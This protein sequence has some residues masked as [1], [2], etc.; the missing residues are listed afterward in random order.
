VSLSFDTDKGAGQYLGEGFDL[1]ALD[2]LFLVFP[3]SSRSRVLQYVGR[4]TRAL[5]GKTSVEVHDYHAALHP[6]LRRM[7]QRRLATLKTIGFV[8]TASP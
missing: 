4:V 2:T 5:P 3:I 1:P 7:L 8:P 6:L